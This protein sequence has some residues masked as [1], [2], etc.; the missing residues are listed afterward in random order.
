MIFY[1]EYD[2]VIFENTG[3]NIYVIYFEI[4][5]RTYNFLFLNLTNE[6]NLYW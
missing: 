5:L 3:K 4:F 1:C 6:K 2:Q